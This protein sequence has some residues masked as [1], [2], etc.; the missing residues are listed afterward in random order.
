MNT[1]KSFHPNPTPN[2]HSQSTPVP[3]SSG[4]FLRA[5]SSAQ[6]LAISL[7]AFEFYNLG[8]GSVDIELP[9]AE[10]TIINNITIPKDAIAKVHFEYTGTFSRSRRGDINLLMLSMVSVVVNEQLFQVQS[11]TIS[12]G[13][14]ADPQNPPIIFIGT[15]AR[16][17]VPIETTI[18]FEV[19]EIS[20]IA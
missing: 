14:F 16:L 12:L 6:T 18:V 15:T 20:P 13:E 17:E 3:Q 2:Q 9:V 4:S 10:T 1:S 8:M 5:S 19:E 11:N 7:P